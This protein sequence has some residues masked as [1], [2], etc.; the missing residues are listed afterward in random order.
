[1]EGDLQLQLAMVNRLPRPPCPHWLHLTCWPNKLARIYRVSQNKLLVEFW[2]VSQQSLPNYVRKLFLGHNVFSLQA[3]IWCHST[4]L[5]LVHLSHAKIWW[6]HIWR[7]LLWIFS[8]FYCFQT[9]SEQGSHEKHMTVTNVG[10]L[11]DEKN[12][13][14]LERAYFQNVL[15]GKVPRRAIPWLAIYIFTEGQGRLIHYSH[16]I[17]AHTPNLLQGG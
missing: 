8:G 17:T 5:P 11:K 16:K 15:H 1:M 9:I 10:R 12:T 4:F 13:K 2:E 6:V 14:N 3:F 7:R